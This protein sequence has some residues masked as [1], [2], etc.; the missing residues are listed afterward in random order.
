[1]NLVIGTLVVA[2]ERVLRL[3]Y[4]GVGHRG[5]S[6]CE[7]GPRGRPSASSQ[8]TPRPAHITCERGCENRGGQV[9]PVRVAVDT[10]SSPAAR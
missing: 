7:D 6:S 2:Y 5:F 4:R 3:D 9:F 1:M 8:T 10:S